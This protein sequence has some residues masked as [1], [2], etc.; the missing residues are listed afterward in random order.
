[1]VTNRILCSISIP[2]VAALA[3]VGCSASADPII[4]KDKYTH[5]ILQNSSTPINLVVGSN[6]VDTPTTFNC[7]SAKGCVVV[8]TV[9]YIVTGAI[10]LM[11]CP[12]VDGVGG[13]PICGEDEVYEL[14]REQLNISQGSHSVATTATTTESGGQITSW[15]TDYMI[16]EIH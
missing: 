3:G 4:I 13:N 8:M 6:P 14:T 10:S 16:Y 7:G 5:A 2:L 12:T 15:E 11:V 9:S 1:M